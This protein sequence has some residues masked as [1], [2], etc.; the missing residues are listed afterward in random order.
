MTP[1]WVVITKVAIWAAC[2]APLALL[3][4]QALGDIYPGS[5]F[6][7]FGGNTITLLK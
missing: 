4:M 3:L 2:L 5:V 1:R 6:Q 7:R